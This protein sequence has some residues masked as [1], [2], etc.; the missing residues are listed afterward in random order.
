MIGGMAQWGFLITLMKWTD[1]IV[2]ITQ[3]KKSF[4]KNQN[5]VLS[6]T[7]LVWFVFGTLMLLKIVLE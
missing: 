5:H 6:N 2:Y 7:R 1:G 3:S 4:K